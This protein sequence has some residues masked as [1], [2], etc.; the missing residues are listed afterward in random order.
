MDV[1]AGNARRELD[2]AYN[3]RKLLQSSAVVDFEIAPDVVIELSAS[4]VR[5]DLI[6]LSISSH[7]F[8]LLPSVPSLDA[9]IEFSASKVSFDQVFAPIPNPLLA[10]QN[11]YPVK[12]EAF[13]C[14]ETLLAVSGAFA[15]DI[16]LPCLQLS[17]V[18]RP[19]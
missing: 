2:E 18:C 6:A 8:G 7:V 13:F 16:A 11:L 1:V 17:S 4:Q 15:C 12:S 10:D 19:C 9:A 14:A 3:G 5:F